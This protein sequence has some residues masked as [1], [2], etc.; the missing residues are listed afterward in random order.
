MTRQRVVVI[1]YEGISALYLSIPCAVFHDAFQYQESPFELTVCSLDGPALSSMSRFSL[2]IAADISALEQA[3]WIIMAGWHDVTTQAPP[4]LL[5]ALQRAHRRGAT[6]VGLCLGAAVLAQS[7]L[8]DGLT[9]TTHWAFA[10]DL[11]QAYPAV[12]VDPD[13]LYLDHGSVVTSAGMA[14]AMDCC[15]HLVRR[16]LGSDRASEV[17]RILVAP[18]YRHGGQKQYIPA[19]V[20]RIR[21]GDGTLARVLEAIQSDL[22]ANHSV[23]SVAERCAM[24]RRTFTRQFRA[25][26]GMSFIPWLTAQ[27]LAYSQRLLE[28]SELAISQIAEQAGFGSESVFR[29]HFKA[30]F[31][32]APR[33]WRQTFGRSV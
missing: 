26:T 29:K 3:D 18:P 20:P 31:D 14:A 5:E 25:Y 13:P 1:A 24:S 2:D 22:T 7:G 16:T 30:A 33:E 21:A 15:L 6:V 4:E 9:A 8:L 32:L 23:A 28:H 17:A 19:P 12:N 10:D 11:A 27:R